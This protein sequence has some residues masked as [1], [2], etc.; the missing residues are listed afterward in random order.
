MVV[1][2]LTTAAVTSITTTTATSGGSITADGGGAIT[3]RGVCWSTAASP[4]TSDSKTSDATGT[5][6]FVS[7]ITGL[8]VGTTYHV[9]AYATNGAGTAY[10]NDL[11]F[12]TIPSAVPTVTTTAV[13]SVTTITAVSG[14][15][16]TPAGAGVIS[17]RGTCWATTAN[18][19][20]SDS[21]TSDA[22]G[23]GIFTSNLTG[24][25]PGTTY[26]IRAY[27]TNSVGTGYGNQIVFNTKISDVD[28]SSYNTVTIGTQVWMAENLKTTKYRDGSLIGT[29]P[30]PA[31]DISAET[32]PKYQWAYGGNET[33]VVT[34]G[35][36]YTYYA[37]T[38]A[39]GVCPTGWHV[40][41]DAE[42]T[43]LHDYLSANGFA[44]LGIIGSDDIAKSMAATSGWTTDPTAGNVG[45]NQASNN[46]S[47]F[48]ALP[49]GYRGIDGVYQQI[50]NQGH[51][52]SSTASIT[53]NQ[54]LY[55]SIDFNNAILGPHDFRSA[56]GYAVRCL[57]N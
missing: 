5:G 10:G 54:S 50:G 35:R 48:T 19:T 13:T 22:T 29:T 28:G 23:T 14:G 36:L 25:L 4:T 17:A 56:N 9:R 21:K 11:S 7:N 24:L 16:I 1:P 53:P 12:T 55:R 31:T 30:D 27:A 49:G 45:N 41:S 37:V 3:A 2:T 6:T 39:R 47:G 34:Y 46:A 20:I 44:F 57:K 51:F 40:P 26:Y 38:D 42:W 43:T 18:P 15:N 33:N 32:A 8:L 52:Y